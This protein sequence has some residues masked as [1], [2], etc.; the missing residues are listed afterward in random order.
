LYTLQEPNS[1]KA[2]SK[3]VEPFQRFRQAKLNVIMTS[4]QS[5]SQSSDGSLLES[6]AFDYSS[7]S[8]TVVITYPRVAFP[9]SPAAS[10]SRGSK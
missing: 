8:S 6:Q 2:N 7:Y 4:V 3:I 5:N 10:T 1:N 9:S